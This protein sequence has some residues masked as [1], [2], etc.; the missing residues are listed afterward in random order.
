MP[1]DD[2]APTV[3]I[4]RPDN[5]ATLTGESFILEAS[6]TEDRRLSE[7]LVTIAGATGSVTFGVSHSGQ[8]PDFK[9]GPFNTQPLA[10]GSND[11]TVTARDLAG[12]EGLSTVTVNRV[13][14]EATLVV[15]EGPVVIQRLRSTAVEARLEETFPGSLDGRDDIDIK[16]AGPDGVRGQVRIRDVPNQ[17]EPKATLEVFAMSRARLG[18]ALVVLNAIEVETTRIIT[19]ADLL[20][21]I[22]PPDPLECGAL[23][24]YYRASTPEELH[25]EVEAGINDAIGDNP[26]VTALTEPQVTFAT[27]EIRIF[28]RFRVKGPIHGFPTADINMS[29]T[30][31]RNDDVPFRDLA[32]AASGDNVDEVV[33]NL[34]RAA[35]GLSEEELPFTYRPFRVNASPNIPVVDPVTAI[36]WAIAKGQFESRFSAVARPKIIRKFNVGIF[37][38]IWLGDPLLPLLLLEARIDI[39]EFMLGFCIPRN[40]FPDPRA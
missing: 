29:A 18:E 2:E 40:Q 13:P 28:S 11:I 5:G 38:S 16:V 32:V 27:N 23:I 34:N 9:V 31:V 17:P 4:A 35:D 6:I 37:K 20:A 1:P 21:S 39:R 25:V 8:A 7:V 12:N 30:I 36:A 26:D 19:A 24:P 33:N 15:P 3:I 22:V 10:P 14:V